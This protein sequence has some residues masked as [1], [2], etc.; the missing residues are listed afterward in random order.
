[1]DLYKKIVAQH[2]LVAKAHALLQL[3]KYPSTEDQQ[4]TYK[5]LDDMRLQDVKRLKLDVES[6]RWGKSPIVTRHLRR[7]K[8]SKVG[9]CYS[10][11]HGEE[12]SVPENWIELQREQE[13]VMSMKARRKNPSRSCKLQ[14]SSTGKSRRKQCS[15]GRIGYKV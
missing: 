15:S 4:E 2:H 9:H 6:F 12:K 8:P 13:S 14:K 11:A 3:T 5:W 7:E 10:N 1:M